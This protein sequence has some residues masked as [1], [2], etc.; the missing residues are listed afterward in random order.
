MQYLQTTVHRGTASRFGELVVGQRKYQ[1]PACSPAVRTKADVSAVVQNIGAGMKLEVLTPYLSR[2]NKLSQ[3]L[4]P[5]ITTNS[6]FMAMYGKP[7]I[8]PDIE[9]ESLN[10]NC[11]ARS[12]F[13]KMGGFVPSV[14]QLLNTGL[15]GDSS[16]GV[17]STHTA[18][19]EV[20][21]K[22]G[23]S[24]VVDWMATSQSAVGSDVFLM[25]TSII[26]SEISTAT[27]AF[28]FAKKMIPAAKAYQGFTMFGI[29]LLIHS[30]IFKTD[31]ESNDTRKAIVDEIHTWSGFQNLRSLFLS[32]K[33][34][35]PNHILT[36]QF[37]GNVVRRNFSYFISDLQEGVQKAGGI[38]VVFNVGNWAL[39]VLDSG[40]DIASFRV[41]GD[42]SI[43]RPMR[44]R[45]GIRN[46]RKIPPFLIP[47]GLTDEDPRVLKRIAAQNNGAFPHTP[48]VNEEEYWEPSFNWNEKVLYTSQER[49]GVLVDV[50]NEYRNAGLDRNIPLKDAVKSRVQQAQNNQELWDMCPSAW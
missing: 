32:L 17:Q 49:C 7:L 44:G 11:I 23:F 36:D 41:S 29:H 35:D 37:L 16:A 47:R 39:G 50:G 46:Q 45:K 18:W 38:L 30:E 2:R 28:Q 13:K 8:L 34:Y 33:V 43:E 40:A 5:L 21:R 6:Q 15:R 20:D 26:R 10:F 19:R 4:K 48:Y 9:S 1:M 27:E 42:T 24:G 31:K 25:P 14:A 22:Y 3:E 12:E